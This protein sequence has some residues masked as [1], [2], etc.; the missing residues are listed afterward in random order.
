MKVAL[1]WESYF[2]PLWNLLWIVILAFWDPVVAS[3]PLVYFWNSFCPLMDLLLSIWDPVMASRPY[4]LFLEQLLSPYGTFYYLLM[5]LSGPFCFILRT[6]L[7]TLGPFFNASMDKYFVWHD[8]INDMKK[9]N[10]LIVSIIGA[11][12]QNE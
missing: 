11:T 4:S 3:R 7:K 8:E 5:E 1:V 12:F 9:L 6:I 10:G 2:I